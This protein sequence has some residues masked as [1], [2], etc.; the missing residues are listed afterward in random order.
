M[1]IRLLV[2]VPDQ[3]ALAEVKAPMTTPTMYSVLPAAPEPGVSSHAVL[4]G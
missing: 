3:V 4:I 2:R 1:T